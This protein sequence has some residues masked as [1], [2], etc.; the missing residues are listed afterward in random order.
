MIEK[1]EL[2][3]NARGGTEMM[4]ERLYKYVDVSL[5]NQFQIIPSRVRHIDPHKKTI[6]YCHDL[7]EDTENRILLNHGWDK[8]DFFVFVSQWQCDAYISMYDIPY[9]KCTVIPNAVE[10]EHK[11]R[12]KD[13]SIIKFV[14]HTT[15]HRGLNIAYSVFDVLSREYS[16]IQFDVFSS[17]EIYGWKQRDAMYK[18]LFDELEAHPKINYHGSKDNQTVLDHL[19]QSHI[20]LYPSTW[21][22]T[23]CIAMIEAIKSSC[24]VIHPNYGALNETSEDNSMSY[25]FAEDANVHA[26]RTFQLTKS[27]LEIENEN[28]GYINKCANNGIHALTKNSISSFTTK[29]TNLL[30]RLINE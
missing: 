21:K 14:Y 19:E 11:A 28:A 20:F 13:N 8:F 2:S 15:P 24:M 23:S 17:F 29:W 6:L 16:N 26:S 5:L 18:P 27:I 9:F 12:Q 25:E 30:E 3:K 1:N 22:E 10:V 4:M 7:A